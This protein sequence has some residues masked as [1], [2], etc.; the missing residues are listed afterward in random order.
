MQAYL[1][2]C[3]SRMDGR[4]TVYC[5]VQAELQNRRFAPVILAT[6]AENAIKH[7]IF[8]RRGGTL[9]IAARLLPDNLEVALTDDG[10]GFIQE[11]GSGLG[12]ANIAERLRLLYG[13]NAMVGWRP[14]THASC[15]PRCAFQIMLS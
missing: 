12:L 13:S 8:P 6:L 7:G 9:W 15:G 2:V 10:L 14:I 1:D 5:E 3:A 4:L 11:A